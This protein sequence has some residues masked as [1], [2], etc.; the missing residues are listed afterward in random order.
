MITIRNGI[1]AILGVVAAAYAYAQPAFA[2]PVVTQETTPGGIVYQRAAMPDAPSQSVQVYWREGALKT[3]AERFWVLQTAAS[4][5]VQGPKGSKRSEFTEALKDLGATVR[6]NFLSD[7]VHLGVTVRADKAS[8][9]AVM[10]GPMLGDPALPPDQFEAARLAAT[11]RL[12]Q[13][14]ENAEALAGKVWMRRLVADTALGPVLARDPALMDKASLGDLKSWIGQ[15]LTRDNMVVATAGPLDGAAMG[16]LIDKLLAGLP[17]KGAPAPIK[18][19]T[20][21]QPAGVVTLEKAVAQTVILAGGPASFDED[22]DKAMLS[23]AVGP[24]YGNSLGGSRL[25]ANLREKLGA[26][27]GVKGV[28]ERLNDKQFVFGVRSAVDHTKAKAAFD[29]LNEE[30]A[31][32][33]AN[34]LT[35]EEFNDT[36]ARFIASRLENVRRSASVAGYLGR[37]ML[38]GG[39][40]DALAELRKKAE[41]MTLAEVNAFIKRAFPPPPLTVVVVTPNPADF[42]A[43]CAI[44]AV[45]EVAGCK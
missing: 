28:I 35:Q 24:L 34:G 37:S 2:Q 5:L 29:A 30:Y 12:E 4:T 38:R 6:V 11:K 20:I 10:V 25:Y 9:A 41:A 19:L 15:T 23:V 42:A 27:Y 40:T 1:F 26:T 21:G 7:S 3:S 16:P 22:R 31:R 32:W 45:D 13:E 43:A 14:R 18:P 39:R 36:R 33:H 17:A 8:E 44:K